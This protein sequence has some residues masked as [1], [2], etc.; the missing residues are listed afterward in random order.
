MPRTSR[1]MKG[2]NM[3]K[4]QKKRSEMDVNYTW[5]LTPIFESDEAWAK[6]FDEVSKIVEQLKD[7]KGTLH[8]ADRLLDYLSFYMELERKI[9]RLYFYAH[10]KHDQDTTD[11]TYQE[12]KGKID[13][14]LNH[15]EEENSF[16]EPE[17]IKLDA[18]TL[19]KFYQDKPELEQYRFTLEG[20]YRYKNHIL[21]KEEEQLLSMLGKLYNHPEDTYTALTDSDL[22]FGFIHDENGEEVELTESN[23]SNFLKSSNRKVRQEAFE[24]LL[25]VYGE[26]KN[27]ITQTFSSNIDVLTTLAKIKQYPDSLTASLFADNIEKEV[28]QNLIDTVHKH[29]EV[30]YHYFNLKK[31]VLGYQELHLYDIY[32]ELIKESDITYS[33]EE[34]K[35]M[36]L[37]ALKPLGEDYIQNLQKAFDEKWIDVYNNVGKRGGAYSSGFYDTNPYILLNY[38]NSLKDVSTLAH[39]LGHSMHTY[40]SCKNNPYQYSSYR[41]F[42]A[43]VA[44]T[45][46]EL[47]LNYHLLEKSNSKEEKLAILNSLMELYKGTIVRQTMFAEFE[48]LEHK[49]VEEKQVLTYDSLC[50]D[51]YE[52][53]KLYFG[54][55][56]IIDDQ[57]KYEWERIPHF[58]YNFYVY[59]YAIGLSCACYIVDGI[60]NKKEKALEN[61][62]AFLKTGGSM[63]PLEELKVAGI[64]VSSP[65]IIESAMKMFDDV[66]NKFETLYFE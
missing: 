49:K 10:L 11:T 3:S 8:T 58:Y 56:V 22:K 5:D 51:Y 63:Y 9:Y 57:I 27:A 54:Q 30:A 37:E 41:I 33:F 14:L 21:S 66:I 4:V 34:A 13:T 53:N 52:L 55:D 60:L 44:S 26:Y 6:S 40:Y 29:I 32:A 25:G 47:L 20:I 23:Y 16:F 38:E 28:Y 48:M 31:K 39:E 12:L 15:L 1:L 42:V 24:R 18:S 19:E 2:N 59:K 50:K 64:D 7:Y 17:L 43:E 36:V 35:K 46:N 65:E 61:Y 45:V 62:L